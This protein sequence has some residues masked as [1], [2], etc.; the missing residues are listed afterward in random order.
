MDDLYH[1]ET[2]TVTAVMMST[3]SDSELAT[4]TSTEIQPA[5][6]VSYY[7]VFLG[8][9]G[10]IVFVAMM[11]MI[12]F[13]FKRRKQRILLS[14]SRHGRSSASNNLNLENINLVEV[15]M[16]LSNQGLLHIKS[17]MNE[18]NRDLEERSSSASAKKFDHNP[19][20]INLDAGDN[21]PTP[22]PPELPIR[23]KQN[24][25]YIYLGPEESSTDVP[26]APTETSRNI[27]CKKNLAYI[28][29]GPAETP[30]ELQ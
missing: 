27:P 29:L 8:A 11:V 13:Y 26:T 20:Y 15:S 10:V 4:L 25:A 17:S 5:D 12:L 3:S 22:S 19:I 9:G 7:Y 21:S 14:P 6:V 28:H 16:V 23:C 30:L 1:T 2:T 24:R 18:R